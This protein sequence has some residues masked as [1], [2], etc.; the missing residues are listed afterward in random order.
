M[1]QIAD[2]PC[3]I[4]ADRGRGLALTLSTGARFRRS[5]LPVSQRLDL[6][7]S[8]CGT[9]ARRFDPVGAAIKMEIVMSI[10][11]QALKANERYAKQS[12]GKDLRGRKLW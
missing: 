8:E 7:L 2:S 5:T 6:S 9:S 12:G 4:G 3:D 10:I 1:R 11:D